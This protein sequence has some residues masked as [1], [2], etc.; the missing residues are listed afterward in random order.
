MLNYSTIK[1]KATVTVSH[2]TLLDSTPS[3]IASE[4]VKKA[5]TKKSWEAVRKT[6]NNP[7][8]QTML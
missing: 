2:S 4:A 8:P 3:P 1:T 5:W 7:A 6:D